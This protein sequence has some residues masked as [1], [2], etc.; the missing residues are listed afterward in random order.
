[1]LQS[2]GSQRV[3]NN[4]AT[5]QQQQQNI[6]YSFTSL[7]LLPRHDSS[8]CSSECPIYAIRSLLSGCSEVSLG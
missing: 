5:E 7:T 2:M 8:V 6:L 4:W 1:M 3:R